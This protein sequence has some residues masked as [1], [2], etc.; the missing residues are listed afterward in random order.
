MGFFRW[1][2]QNVLQREYPLI[3]VPRFPRAEVPYISWCPTKISFVFHDLVKAVWGINDDNIA[4]ISTAI[5]EHEIIHDI[6]RK[7][8]GWRATHSLNH[9]NRFGV[10]NMTLI[11][12]FEVPR[13]GEIFRDICR[14]GSRFND[15]N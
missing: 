8:A 15:D 14:D 4:Q 2:Y 5:L 3:S 12:M 11:W 10:T 9:V 1:F 7:V 13:K 6:V